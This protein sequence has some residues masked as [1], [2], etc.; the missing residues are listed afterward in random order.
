MS[1]L[2]YEAQIQPLIR[3]R[4]GGTVETSDIKDSLNRCIRGLMREHGIYITKDSFTCEVFDGVDR[5]P[6]P[7]DFVDII[8]PTTYG[9]TSFERLKPSDFLISRQSDILAI[10]S[11][12]NTHALMLNSSLGG[13]KETIHDCASITDNGTWA[14]VGT[15]DAVNMAEKSF[16]PI[17]ISAITFN[18]I[19]ATQAVHYAEVANSTI[20]S[21]DLSDY[22]NKG[23]IFVDIFIPENANLI[24]SVTINVGTDATNYITSVLTSRFDGMA[25]RNGWN[26]IGMVWNEA[27]E[28]GTN[29]ASD[30]KYAD[31]KI[32]YQSTMTDTYGFAFADL[33]VCLPDSIEIPYHSNNFV[34]DQTTGATKQFFENT[35]D[36]SLLDTVDDDIL[37]YHALKDTYKILREYDDSKLAERDYMTALGQ[38]KAR[39]GSERKREVRFYR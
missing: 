36:Y 7:S 5:Y 14:I 17:G 16:S 28:T 19:V 38:L 1:L 20:S 8:N 23:T 34:V 26:T 30:I 2:E 4:T 6:L 21:I 32:T 15:S 33:R 27:I 3:D 35:G 29:N 9:T 12:K 13:A 37:L 22:E 11:Y 39:Y 24:S 25:F 10:D 18:A 31:I